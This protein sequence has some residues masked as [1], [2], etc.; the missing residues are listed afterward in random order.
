M[1]LNMI[2]LGNVQFSFGSCVEWEISCGDLST[3]KIAT[4]TKEFSDGQKLSSS[5]REEITAG[6]ACAHSTAP[7]VC[8]DD[9]TGSSTNTVTLTC[10]KRE[11]SDDVTENLIAEEETLLEE[12]AIAAAGVLALAAFASPPPPMF[13]PQGLP[14]PQATGGGI[15]P[16]VALTV[17]NI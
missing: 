16:A 14:Q 5:E 8:D 2:L 9:T 7:N 17:S 15:L 6:C 13:P 3:F 10:S 4:L 1:V 12:G 11:T